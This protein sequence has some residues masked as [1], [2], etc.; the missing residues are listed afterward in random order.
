M[1][2]EEKYFATREE[3]EAYGQEYVKAWGYAYCPSYSVGFEVM[4]NQWACYLSR[5]TSC[6]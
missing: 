5:W 6:D 1:I 3:A 2:R 4:A